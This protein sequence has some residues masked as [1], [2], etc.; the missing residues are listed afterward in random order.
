MT[1]PDYIIAAIIKQERL[2]AE[3]KPI[4]LYIELDMPQCVIEDDKEDR[5]IEIITL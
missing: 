3:W 2:E 5:G 1:L 4:E